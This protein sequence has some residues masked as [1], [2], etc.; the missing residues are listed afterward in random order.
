MGLRCHNMAQRWMKLD[1]F[2]H[3]LPC[4]PDTDLHVGWRWLV[5][6]ETLTD[7]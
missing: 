7:S 5:M 1:D 4:T 3:E 6:M 2:N